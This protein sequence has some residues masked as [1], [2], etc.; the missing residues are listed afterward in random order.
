MAALGVIVDLQVLED[1]ASG[2]VSAQQR[3]A[4]NQLL[5][6]R[7]EETLARSALPANVNETPAWQ[8]DY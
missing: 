4:Q 8:K 3:R 7:A 6:E 1:E 5:L 2:S